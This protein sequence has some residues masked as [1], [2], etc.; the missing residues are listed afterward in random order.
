[1][2]LEHGRR[3]NSE[4]RAK[5][6][7]AEAAYAEYGRAYRRWL[8]A[9]HRH[10]GAQ[11]RERERERDMSARKAS[12]AYHEVGRALNVLAWWWTFGE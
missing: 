3:R 10:G 6:R 11:S 8:A 12:R 1:M 7:E 2:E 5:I 4:I 9:F